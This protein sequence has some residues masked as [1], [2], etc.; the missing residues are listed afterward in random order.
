MFSHENVLQVSSSLQ[1]KWIGFLPPKD[2]G[3]FREHK[4]QVYTQTPTG[5]MV[6]GAVASNGLKMPPDFINGGVKVNTEVYI[7]VLKNQVLP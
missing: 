1:R 5:V 3:C 4:V 6:F 2:Q 7:H